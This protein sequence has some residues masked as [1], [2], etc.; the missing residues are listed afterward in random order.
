[1]SVD[2]DLAE[3]MLTQVETMVDLPGTGA[4]VRGVA[5]DQAAQEVFLPPPDPVE[6]DPDQA[7]PDEVTEELV[8]TVALRGVDAGP[9]PRVDGT[10]NLDASCADLARTWQAKRDPMDPSKPAIAMT[11]ADHLDPL[12]LAHMEA[13]PVAKKIPWA[14]QAAD[15][16]NTAYSCDT[17]PVP[18]S[19]PGTE[20]G[21]NLS[22]WHDLPEDHYQKQP[23]FAQIF[24][25]LFLLFL[26]LPWVE[27]WE[28]CA[29]FTDLYAQ[30]TYT[31]L[32]KEYREQH[33]RTPKRRA[34]KGVSTCVWKLV[35]FI[36]ILI[37]LG[38]VR[39]GDRDHAACW[40]LNG[41]EA[42]HGVY[43]SF[44]A[45]AMAPC[46]WTNSSR[47]GALCIFATTLTL[48]RSMHA[49]ASTATTSQLG[50]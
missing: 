36:G 50:A 42:N 1:M 41:Y 39:N 2:G 35:R 22:F 48:C 47:S 18:R 17:E 16:V 19:P 10:S 5:D 28:P 12:F 21:L 9:M 34:W 15:F 49:T 37:F 11:S 4:A 38:A 30:Q 33:G 45:G 8:P 44:V 13:F 29:D 32:N 7:S 46:H 40:D 6:S 20:P 25:P 23:T 14:P 27:F 43:D 26:N 31:R 24:D 3:Q